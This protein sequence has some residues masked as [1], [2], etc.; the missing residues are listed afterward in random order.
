MG[1]SLNL[2]LMAGKYQKRFEKNA[3]KLFTF[4]DYDGIPWNNNS[5]ENA[6]KAFARRRVLFNGQVSEQGVKD[7]AVLLSIYQTCKY[8]GINFLDFLLSK[9]VDIDCF[10]DFNK[11]ARYNP[12]LGLP[13]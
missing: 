6:V 12:D 8:K 11:R 13:Q 3:L 9:T 1:L 10:Q 2:T 7:Y 5:A 4:L